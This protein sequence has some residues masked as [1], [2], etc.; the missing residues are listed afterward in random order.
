VDIVSWLAFGDRHLAN[1]LYVVVTPFT[2]VFILPV[3]LVPWLGV[4]QGGKSGLAWLTSGQVLCILAIT[5]WASQQSL[6]D[7]EF[8]E[9]AVKLV[10]R[11]GALFF[12]ITTFSAVAAWRWVKTR[13]DKN[14]L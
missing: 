1:Q 14:E 12:V 8:T 11:I 3:I 2:F 13:R 5:Y 4:W 9:D 7:A 6:A 10:M